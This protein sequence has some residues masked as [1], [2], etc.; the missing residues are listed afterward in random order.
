[1]RRF[2]SAFAVASAILM[3]AAC[4]GKSSSEQSSAA[5]SAGAQA[6]QAAGA[7]E[8]SAPAS[9]MAVQ[10]GAMASPSSVTIP[11]YPGATTQAV[12]NNPAVV[13]RTNASGKVLVTGDSFDKV[14]VWYQQHMPE[15][16]ERLHVTQPAPAAAFVI[17]E[18]N[19]NQDSVAI[20][21][22]GGKT[23]IT[24]AHVITRKPPQ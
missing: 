15:G 18:A 12:S 21:A 1:M 9:S 3:L 17:T 23:V 2:T 6:T 13:A 5:A 14:Y 11:E 7:Q 8:S 20:S 24:I 16:S 22:R 10:P 4:S 19:S